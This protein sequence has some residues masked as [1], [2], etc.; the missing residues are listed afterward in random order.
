MGMLSVEWCAEGLVVHLKS[1]SVL[2]GLM[3]SQIFSREGIQ[4]GAR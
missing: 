4:E 1:G 3:L 2:S